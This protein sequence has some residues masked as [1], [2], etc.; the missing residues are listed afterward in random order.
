MANRPGKRADGNF[1]MWQRK[2]GNV[3]STCIWKEQ[4]AMGTADAMYI[5]SLMPRY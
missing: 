1:A 5:I 4:H 2:V 3:L